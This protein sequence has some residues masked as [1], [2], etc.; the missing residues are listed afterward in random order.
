[1]EDAEQQYVQKGVL[2]H[3]VRQWE[4]SNGGIAANPVEVVDG[5]FT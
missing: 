5:N 2:L 3:S 4:R 1:M